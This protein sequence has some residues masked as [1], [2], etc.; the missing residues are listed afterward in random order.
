MQKSMVLVVTLCVIFIFIGLLPIHG[1]S[2]VY[3]N[4]LRLHVLANSDSEEDQALKL[5]VRD[6]ILNAA[7]PLLADCASREEAIETVRSNL[8]VL[9]TAAREAIAAEGRNDPVHLELGEEI[10]PTRTYEACS[11][12]SGAYQSLRV[13]IG[14]AEGQNWWCVLFP[15]MCLSAASAQAKAPEDAFISVGL[16]G[17][18]YRII[19]ETD[20]PTYTVRF[21]I[22]EVLEEAMR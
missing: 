4:V 13:M 21:R 11:F 8:S 20:N 5:K 10:Y 1:E 2:D 12:P 3:Q 14:E 18:Q 22:L 16:T 7:G 6:A 17:D 15:P 19:T 9:E